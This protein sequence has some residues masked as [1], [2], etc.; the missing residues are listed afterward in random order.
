M[1]LFKHQRVFKEVTVLIKKQNV[2]TNG[3]KLTCVKLVVRMTPPPKQRR[4]EMSSWPP[5]DV[6][7]SPSPQNLRNTM[8]RIPTNMEMA[9]SRTIDTTLAIR[10]PILTCGRCFYP[11]AT[12]QM[13][14]EMFGIFCKYQSSLFLY[15][16]YSKVTV[17]KFLLATFLMLAIEFYDNSGNFS[18]I[19]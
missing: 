8:G 9:P 2:L 7:L 4:A 3:T 19:F 17:N 10:T 5:L 18:F 1:S 12:F 15:Y 6:R 11:L 14:S 13:G 16:L